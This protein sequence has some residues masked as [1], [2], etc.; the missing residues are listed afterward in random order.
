MGNAVGRRSVLLKSSDRIEWHEYI[1][2]E[3]RADGA[4]ELDGLGGLHRDPVPRGASFSKKLAFLEVALN[5]HGTELEQFFKPQGQA[6]DANRGQQ[7]AKRSSKIPIP[8][9]LAL[10]QGRGDAP[11]EWRVRVH[12]SRRRVLLV[13]KCVVLLMRGKLR[14]APVPRLDRFDFAIYSS[15]GT[16]WLKVA[17][18][19]QRYMMLRDQVEAATVALQDAIQAA[20]A[21]PPERSATSTPPGLPGRGPLPPLGGTGGPGGT[22]GAASRNASGSNS[23]QCSAIS[24][25]ML[26]VDG[27]PGE[28]Q[29]QPQPPNSPK[30]LVAPRAPAG[31]IAVLTVGGGGGRGG[32]GGGGGGE[33][34]S[35]GAGPGGGVGAARDVSPVTGRAA[36]AAA[37]NGVPGGA[38]VPL[39]GGRI[40]GVR[41][42]LG[43]QAAM[44][45]GRQQSQATQAMLSSGAAANATAAAAA[46]GNQE[47]TPVRVTA[48]AAATQAAVQAAAQAAAA[49]NIA[50]SSPTSPLVS[51]VSVDSYVS[52]GASGLGGGAR[53]AYVSAPVPHMDGLGGAP[54]SP[55]PPPLDLSFPPV[56]PIVVPSSPVGGGGVAGTPPGKR[57]SGLFIRARVRQGPNTEPVVSLSSL[58]P[59]QGGWGSGAVVPPTT[60]TPVTGGGVAMPPA[61]TSLFGNPLASPASEE[62]R[63]STTGGITAGGVLGAGAGGIGSGA[64]G[65]ELSLSG[66]IVGASAASAGG[67]TPASAFLPVLPESP[68][69]AAR[70]AA[71][72]WASNSSTTSRTSLLPGGS[73]GLAASPSSDQLPKLTTRPSLSKSATARSLA[74]G[75]HNSVLTESLHAADPTAAAGLTLGRRAAGGLSADGRAAAMQPG[76]SAHA[77]LAAEA[78]PPAAGSA[79]AL[80]TGPRYSLQQIPARHS[81]SGSGGRRASY[82]GVGGV[83]VSGGVGVAGGPDASGGG[84]IGSGVLARRAATYKTLAPLDDMM[85]RTRGSVEGPALAAAVAA[86]N[87][88]GGAAAALSMSAGGPRLTSQLTDSLSAGGGPPLRSALSGPNMLQSG[89]VCPN[90]GGSGSASFSSANSGG[91]GAGGAPLAP[92]VRPVAVTALGSPA[93]GGGGTRSGGGSG[94]SSFTHLSTDGAPVGGPLPPTPSGGGGGGGGTRA[95]HAGVITPAAAS[96]STSPNGGPGPSPRPP[97]GPIAGGSSVFKTLSVLRHAANCQPITS[98]GGAA[99]AAAGTGTA[100]GD[101]PPS[102]SLPALNTVAGGAGAGA[103]AAGGNAANGPVY[104]S[105][106]AAARIEVLKQQLHARLE[107]LHRC[108]QLISVFLNRCNASWAEAQTWSAPAMVTQLQLAAFARSE[109]GMVFKNELVHMLVTGTMAVHLRAADDFL[110][111]GLARSWG[112]QGGAAGGAGGPTG[113][114][115]EGATGGGDAYP[116]GG[117]P[118]QLG[119]DGPGS[120]GSNAA[121]GVAAAAAGGTPILMSYGSGRWPGAGG[122]GGTSSGGYSNGYG[123]TAGGMGPSFTLS[124]NAG[125]AASGAPG[126]SPGGVGFLGGLGLMQRSQAP[127]LWTHDPWR[128]LETHRPGMVFSGAR[129]DA[130]PLGCRYVASL[131]LAVEAVGG[132]DAVARLPL[133]LVVSEDQQDEVVRQLWGF[134][135]FGIRRENVVVVVQPSHPGYC[136]DSENRTWN[137][138]DA[139]HSLP[140]GSGYGLMQ[141]AWAGEAMGVGEDG[142]LA[143]LPLSALGWMEARGVR[144]LVSRR[145]RDLTLLTKD[146]VLDINSLAYGLYFHTDRAPGTNIIMEAQSSNN[147]LLSRALDSIIMSRKPEGG[148]GRADTPPA[149]AMQV[150]AAASEAAPN[151]TASGAGAGGGAGGGPRQPQVVELCHTDLATPVMRAVLADCQAA[152]RVLTGVGR[153]MMH[154]PSIKEMLAGRLSVLRPKLGLVDDLLHLRLELADVTSAPAA[155]SLLLQA[156]PD[157]P[158]LLVHDDVDALL[159]LLQA[160]DN[161]T[162]FRQLIMS[163]R[164][165]EMRLAAGMAPPGGPGPRGLAMSHPAAQRIVV[166]VVANSVSSAAVSMAASLARPGRDNVTIATV[167]SDATLFRDRAEALLAKHA[168]AFEKLCAARYFCEVVDRGSYGLIDCMENYATQHGATLVVMGSNS[169]TSGVGATSVAAS[170][171]IMPSAAAGGGSAGGAAGGAA[172]GGSGGGSAARA[173]PAAAT[174]AAVNAASLIHIV[175]SVTLALLRRMP[176]PL[177][178]VTRSSHANA[179]AAATAATAEKEGRRRPIKVMAVLEG[180]AKGLV[181]YLAGKAINTSGGDQLFLSYIRPTINMTRQQQANVKALVSRYLHQVASQGMRP[182][183]TLLLDAPMDRALAAAV[184]EHGIDLLALPA[185][186]RNSQV[187]PQ[188]VATLRSAGCA[189][190]WHRDAASGALTH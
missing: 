57:T 186:P 80:G 75:G 63:R 53:N 50:G 30:P 76:S 102:G 47:L 46:A 176:V 10:K 8:T 184:S 34:S 147:L 148:D 44:H 104:V 52:E 100:A 143:P 83:T 138:G 116:A 71:A 72:P 18:E 162:T 3:W 74:P 82:D 173:Q 119:S 145:A 55:R 150:A 157:S 26:Q 136:Y 40:H 185:G 98:A 137:Q 144:W 62:R 94:R 134:R 141:L 160:Q 182:T 45:A 32:G 130:V 107:D 115:G 188:V 101:G 86:A 25:P 168:G 164:D 97:P 152:G 180:Q 24:V 187:P 29:A 131:V 140:L 61:R 14:V 33:G 159:P 28:P 128:M 38:G 21:P 49:A 85:L 69:A 178:L 120:P 99:E 111:P 121:A 177:L 190:L 175:G 129:L 93:G 165:E 124:G 95:T 133:V 65:A 51:S 105:E 19:Q 78:D 103:G 149:A 1:Q 166:F 170:L 54:G 154:L 67:S 153:Y 16:D 64:V 59:G 88:G 89:L 23:P 183:Q 142:C 110:E 96:A 117:R 20:T 158:Q 113:G 27:P 77:L 9:L 11:A 146:G 163:C 5:K 39:G 58:G 70:R 90:G 118:S 66:G 181:D 43:G 6:G 171:S 112:L 15:L 151:A 179:T 122:G 109:S 125:G 84:G 37:A 68:S 7:G 155:S 132:R 81:H 48:A 12:A 79:A 126:S 106:E 139:S 114:G 169:L 135:F 42:N 108:S 156:R 22:S 161:N 172:A 167:V 2:E 35:G 36:A 31:G 56:P 127:D 174:A 87:S 60:P 13:I 92:G 17:E 41:S 4:K 189:V 73:G 91:G 123:T